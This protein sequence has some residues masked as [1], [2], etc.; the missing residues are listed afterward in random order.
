[1]SIVC[2]GFTFLFSIGVMGT[3]GRC[4]NQRSYLARAAPGALDAWSAAALHLSTDI[5]TWTAKWMLS[6]AS[7]CDLHVADSHSQ[8]QQLLHVKLD[9]G[10]HSDVGHHV[11][12]VGQQ[13]REPASLTQAWAQD[14][15]DLL[16]QRRWSQKKH[17]ASQLAAYP[18][19]WVDLSL[20]VPEECLSFKGS[21]LLELICSITVSNNCW[22]FYWLWGR[23]TCPC[24]MP[25]V[26]G[27]FTALGSSPEKSRRVLAVSSHT[28]SGFICLW[29]GGTRHH[30]HLID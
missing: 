11:P 22:S 16:D 29:A 7:S 10:F 24:L 8:T 12:A 30:R 26:A 14:S 13:G 6:P 2:K 23:T 9:C 17:P 19:V 1:M 3:L 28:V 27:D 18:W 5:R 15:W 21:E 4:S 20:M 25:H